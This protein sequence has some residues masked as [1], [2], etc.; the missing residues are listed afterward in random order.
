MKVGR[1][2]DQSIH[3]LREMDALAS[4]HSPVHARSAGAKLFVTAVF[5]L[6]AASFGKYDL[7]GL[8]FMVLY[9]AVLFS[10]SGI[11]VSTCFYKLRYVLPLVCA[12]GLF[13]P[14][15]DRTPA[16]AAGSFVVTGGMISM[17]TLMVKGVL[18][19]AASFLL[20]A[21]TR[22]EAVCGAL[23]KIHV[24]KLLVSLLLL[25]YR[26]AAVL[27]GEAAVMTDA[28]HLRAPGQ[29]GIHYSAWGSFFGQLMLRSVD[30]A[31]ELYE[32]M[33]LRGYDG[34]FYY[35]ETGR[36]SAADT[37]YVLLW[38]AFFAAARLFNLT[39]LLGGVLIR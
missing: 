36:W 8:I 1:T 30:R 14:F 32:S 3:D 17:L 28:Y 10:L 9:P 15:F 18:C 34:E 37:V 24:P 26:Y 25:T 6:T 27:A 33:L 19:L 31:G 35:A 38:C 16:F 39:R 5:I 23:R 20:A 2:I 4:G 22:I 29:K 12:V 11:P 7:S 13:N 21:T